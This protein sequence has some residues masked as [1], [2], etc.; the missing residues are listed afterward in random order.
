M[1][2]PRKVAVY[3]NSLFLAG[4][5]VGL[6]AVAG[7][8]VVRVDAAASGA[9][10]QLLD[11]QPDAIIFELSPDSPL[12]ALALPFLAQSPDRLLIG[13][14]VDTNEVVVLSSQQIRPDSLSDLAAMIRA[15]ASV[16]V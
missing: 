5:E 11:A 13:L 2:Q 8:E 7:L 12:A 3:G 9:L 10:G 6:R 14:N 1:A 15:P 4:V 16:P